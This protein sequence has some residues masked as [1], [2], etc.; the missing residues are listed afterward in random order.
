[1]ITIY[2]KPLI[3]NQKTSF[4]KEET[5]PICFRKSEQFKKVAIA[6]FNEGFEYCG[7]AS[8]FFGTDEFN[9]YYKVVKQ[10]TM[11]KEIWNI[12]F[13]S[14]DNAIDV[15]S[16]NELFTKPISKENFRIPFTKVYQFLKSLED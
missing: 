4:E 10:I 11:F 14:E 8:D 7:K 3:F 9:D 16:N 13:S 6:L 2:F 12:A 1:M 5:E 15:F